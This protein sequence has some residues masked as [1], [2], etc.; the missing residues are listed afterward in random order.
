MVG[1]K[2]VHYFYILVIKNKLNYKK[3][4][5]GS[6]QLFSDPYILQNKNFKMS[7]NFFSNKRKVVQS[8]ITFTTPT[9]Q[10]L[11]QDELTNI[12]A[13]GSQAIKKLKTSINNNNVDEGNIADPTNSSNNNNTMDS[14][15]FPS[16]NNAISSAGEAMNL[17]TEK[18]DESGNFENSLQTLTTLAAESASTLQLTSSTEK[19][20]GNSEDTNEQEFI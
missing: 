19:G 18:N 17:D 8:K 4:Q 10:I 6:A 12:S 3:L 14:E 1:C 11:S 15:P 9:K 20:K 13:D 7:F 5:K 16:T 2:V